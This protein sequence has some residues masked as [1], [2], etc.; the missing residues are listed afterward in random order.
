MIDFLKNPFWSIDWKSAGD[1]V[2]LGAAISETIG[3]IL[4][5]MKRVRSDRY[6]GEKG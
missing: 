6:D 4:P 5:R 1:A 3:G 2:V